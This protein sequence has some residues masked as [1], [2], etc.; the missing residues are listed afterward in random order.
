MKFALLAL[1]VAGVISNT[2]TGADGDQ[3]L[4]TYLK[5]PGNYDP[6]SRQDAI[7]SWCTGQNRT[8]ESVCTDEISCIVAA[9]TYC[10]TDPDCTAVRSMSQSSRN[11]NWTI[12]V[13]RSGFPLRVSDTYAQEWEW[14]LKVDPGVPPVL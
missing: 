12:A 4:P 9:Q 11:I 13:N 2:R 6:D 7:K 10:N 14:Y 3:D 5:L 8:C 1:L